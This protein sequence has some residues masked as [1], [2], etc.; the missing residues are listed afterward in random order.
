MTA[1]LSEDL[2]YVR[3]LAEAGQ[4]APLL[5]GRF[6]MMW[7]LLAS[8]GYAGHYLLVSGT[9][10]GSGIAYVWL[11]GGFSVIGITGQVLLL[12]GI[13]QKPGASS[14][15]NQVEGTVWCSAG[16]ALFAF[17][18]GLTV[19]S[20]VDGSPAQG[21]QGSFSLVFAAYGIGLL[22][23]GIIGRTTV[24]RK[25]GYAALVFVAILTFFT[26]TV[27]VWLIASVGALLTVFIPGLVLIRQEPTNTV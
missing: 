20:L 16:F 12:R 11:W 24:L 26:G 15:G 14:I 19:K 4:T 17:F 2:T 23:S 8:L 5:G 21:F 9:I 27:Y 3:D 10:A 25:A 6:L 18:A 13:R 1:T 7:G 22:T